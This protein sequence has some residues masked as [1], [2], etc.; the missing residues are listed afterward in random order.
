MSDFKQL[1]INIDILTRGWFIR[2]FIIL[3][4]L[5]V[6]T[7]PFFIESIDY[8]FIALFVGF[9]NAFLYL[10][11]SGRIPLL[12][13]YSM[14]TLLPNY[15][16]RLKSALLVILLV[17]FLPTLAL[18]P[19][20]SLWLSLI[21]I[22][23]IMA[24][25]FV[26]MTYHQKFYWLFVGVILTPVS[27]EQLSLFISTDSVI[28][29]LPFLMPIL[30]IWSY[31]LLSKLETFKGD[32]KHI[33]RMIAL[34][35]LSVKKSIASQDNIPLKSRH[36][37]WQ[38]LINS[39][40]DY[41]RK[42]L[43][44]NKPLKNS[45]LIEISCQS[46]AT[47]GPYTYLFWTV[48]VLLFVLIGSLIPPSAQHFLIPMML[49]FPAMMIGAGT[50]GLFQ[51]INNKKSLLQRIAI[52]PNF[53]S[54][55][56]FAKAFLTYIVRNQVQLYI[57]I[58]LVTAVLAITFHHISLV[59]VINELLVGSVLCVSNLTIM[60]WSW[61]VKKNNENSCVWL[62]VLLFIGFIVFLFVVASDETILLYQS[63][64]FMNLLGA[65][66]ILFLISLYRSYQRI[67]HWLA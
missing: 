58:S 53:N 7:M 6:F 32:Q 47:I 24:V 30:A 61:S 44:Q 48:S 11:V 22:C 1:T 16:S 33:A 9:S 41:Y 26:A 46:M 10:M 56:M 25:L 52:L 8:F 38:W 54:Q 17:S 43:K 13:H 27:F 55:Q 42:L 65:S 50:I 23:L 62:M 14:N 59:M 67:P 31:Y 29:V 21:S 60:L 20:F 18:L 63:T 40:F 19:H 28:A 45:K 37:A 34:T 49:A 57:F 2:V 5:L 51:I 66:F 12:A 39:N 3:L 36:R 4:W 15:F 35:S 64:I